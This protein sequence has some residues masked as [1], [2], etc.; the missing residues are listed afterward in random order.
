MSMSWD[1]TA[2]RHHRLSLLLVLV[3]LSRAGALRP[4]EL[5]PYGELWGDR[6]PREGDVESSPAVKLA[7]PLCFYCDQFSNLYVGTN[8]IISTRTYPLPP[9]PLLPGHLGASG[10]LG[11][12]QAWG[13]MVWRG[14]FGGENSV[15]F[16]FFN[17]SKHPYCSSDIAIG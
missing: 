14:E 15:A 5:F 4:V 6:L 17:F 7:V 1:P 8:G 9:Y 3:L 2:R 16:L 11:G 13:C 10:R 12:G